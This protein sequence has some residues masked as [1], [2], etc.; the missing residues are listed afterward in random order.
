[1]KPLSATII[2]MGRIGM[3]LATFFASK[4]VRI[5]GVE[6]DVNR[7]KMIR[8]GGIGSNEPGLN[9]LYK[10]FGARIELTDLATAVRLT[11]FSFIVVPTP[12]DVDGSLC[13]KAIQEVVQEIK[14]A[15][16]PGHDHI[17]AIVSTVSPGTTRGPLTEILGPNASVRLCYN[18]VF[19]A[20]GSV[21]SG[22]ESPPFILIGADNKAAGERLAAFYE[23]LGFS[24]DLIVRMDG[25]NAEI[26][27]LALNAFL[28]T[29][30]AFANSVAAIC[31]NISG[32]DAARVL[33]VVGRDARVGCEYLRPGPPYGG[34]CLPR[35]NEALINLADTCGV[36]P[37]MARAIK[38]S[39]DHWYETLL[40]KIINTAPHRNATFGLAG[41]S[42][43]RNTD[44]LNG[45]FG[46]R[47]SRDLAARGCRVIAY[48]PEIAESNGR[49]LSHVVFATSI[50][51]MLS[52]C[53]LCVVTYPDADLANSVSAAAGGKTV[54]T[55]W[56]STNEVHNKGP[57]P[58]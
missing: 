43:K 44:Y 45:G 12:S 21:L 42:Y 9:D 32:A 57:K 10:R 15:I 4:G 29:K 41:L 18:P 26:T 54:I 48:A 11:N 46:L 20:L 25:L 31:E 30:I 52:A 50:P 6:S 8:S 40:K 22:L 35:D 13:N 58:S 3:S 1:M 39:N 27:K 55:I 36:E 53:D 2:G 51:E 16:G 38:Q 24:R 56:P 14:R 28:T 19:V 5:M 17:A 34:P 33:S 37:I 49:I 47:L 23:S 7:R